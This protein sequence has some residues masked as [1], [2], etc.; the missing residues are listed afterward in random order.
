MPL[1]VRSLLW[2]VVIIAPG[3]L[4]LLPFLAA[5]HLKRSEKARAVAVQ[6]Q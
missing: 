4:L 3:G 1:L 6:Q 5:E 2:C